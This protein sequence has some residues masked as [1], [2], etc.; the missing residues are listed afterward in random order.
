MVENEGVQ[1]QGT[2]V[3]LQTATVKVTEIVDDSCWVETYLE[4]TK[5]MS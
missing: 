3:V 4:D 1:R 5:R 2:G